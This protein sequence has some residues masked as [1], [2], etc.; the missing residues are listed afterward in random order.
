MYIYIYIFMYI[1]PHPPQS[2]APPCPSPSTGGPFLTARALFAA[3][4]PHCGG[5]DGAYGSGAA[6]PWA[7]LREARNPA[8]PSAHTKARAQQQ[9]PSLK[10]DSAI[11]IAHM[12]SAVF[13]QDSG[14]STMRSW[15]RISLLGNNV[16]VFLNMTT[17]LIL[18]CCSK[19]GVSCKMIR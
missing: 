5:G 17:V 18:I 12:V 8:S 19:H 11:T 15:I 2:H 10:N 7:A 1:P 4:R 9:L 3:P 14:R 13:V 6:P 16:F